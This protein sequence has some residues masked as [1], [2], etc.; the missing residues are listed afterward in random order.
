MPKM[1]FRL[2]QVALCL[3]LNCFLFV[4][5][6]DADQSQLS[7]S[8][9]HNLPTAE[10]AHRLDTLEKQLKD[11]EKKSAK[12]LSSL[13]SNLTSSDRLKINGFLSAGI[14]KGDGDYYFGS[15]EKKLELDDK[16]NFRGDSVAGLQF[17]VNVTDRTEVVT[18][19]I[20][21]GIANFK[22]EAEWAFV[23]QQVTDNTWFRAGR[24]RLPF[25]LYSES[26]EVGFTYPWVRP[27]IDVYIGEI[28]SY[29][30]ADTNYRFKSGGWTHFLQI[31][32]GGA[33]SDLF[34]ISDIYGANLQSDYNHFSTRI[35]YA[36]AGVEINGLPLEI[37]KVMYYV[38]SGSYDNGSWV[39][40][41]ETI[42][43][44]VK[45]GPLYTQEGGY[46]L[47]GKYFNRWSTYLT[48]S[49]RYTTEENDDPLATAQITSPV[50]LGGQGDPTGHENSKSLIGDIRYNLTSK[51]ALKFETQRTFAFRKD[52]NGIVNNGPF[53][54][55]V[56]SS[57]SDALMIYSFVVDAVF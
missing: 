1:G 56:P 23:K 13:K 24:M 25:Y 47:V 33:S 17:N 41:A 32:T 53:S 18:Q 11:S 57:E 40:T 49:Y 6:V 28:T 54:G 19:F 50:T 21:K 51:V 38:V 46:L 7:N 15:Q 52:P 42:K 44:D 20:S 22:T 27:P 16:L 39:T 37:P 12:R 10:L 2:K 5:N 3:P 34:K 26:I 48:Y 14:V 8:Q 29:E 30:G 45:S 31:Y 35:S 9:Q 43:Q 55:D 36:Q 4:T